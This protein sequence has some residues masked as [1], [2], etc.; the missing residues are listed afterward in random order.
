MTSEIR[1]AFEHPDAR[2]KAGAPELADRISLRDHIVEVDIGAFQQERGKTQRV[3][4]NVVVEVR[5]L[6]EVSDDVDRILSYDKVS[7]AIAVELAKERLNLLETLAERIAERILLE[8]QALRVFV[9]IEKLDRGPGALG[10][11][12]VRSAKDFSV[13]P[14]EHLQVGPRPQIICLSND[15]VASAS[16]SGWLDTLSVSDTPSII[17]VDLPVDGKSLTGHAMVDRRIAL[18]SIEQNAWVLAS[19]DDRCVVVGSKTELDWAIKHNELC[20]WAPSKMV[21]DA[22]QPPKGPVSDTLGLALWLGHSL[23]AKHVMAIGSFD[24]E[25][26]DPL[27]L[28]R[29]VGPDAL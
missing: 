27:I 9:R 18:L 26:D 8:P 1:L 29:G 10:V 28:F 11:E 21:L 14:A 7:E 12:I 17:C 24:S 15:A 2:S 4:F 3:C 5:P 6:S 19:K 23:N 16:L 22:T 13:E 25:Q 20:V